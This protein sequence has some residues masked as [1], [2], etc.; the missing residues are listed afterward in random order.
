MFKGQESFLEMTEVNKVEDLER[1]AH[2]GDYSN[3]NVYSTSNATTTDFAA[4]RSASTIDTLIF[5]VAEQDK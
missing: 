5:S 4:P 1:L 3:S 2:R